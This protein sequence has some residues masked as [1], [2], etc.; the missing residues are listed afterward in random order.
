MIAKTTSPR[1]GLLFLTSLLR[2]SPMWVTI[3]ELQPPQKEEPMTNIHFDD[4]GP[5]NASGQYKMRSPAPFQKKLSVYASHQT[6]VSHQPH[7]SNQQKNQPAHARIPSSYQRRISPF[8]S[9]EQFRNSARQHHPCKG[10]SS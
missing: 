3:L 2:T 9:F 7:W 1:L 5:K 10:Q 8:R 6:T 4:E